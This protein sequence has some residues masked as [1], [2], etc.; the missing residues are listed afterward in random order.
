MDENNVDVMEEVITEEPLKKPTKKTTSKKSE[1]VVVKV[2][3]PRKYE[4][5]DV[6]EC[7]SVFPGRFYF[8]GPKTKAIYP[9][10]ANGDICYVEYQ[11]LLSAMLAKKKSI[12]APYIV[13]DD[14]ELING[15]H[16][17]A[18]KKVY[19]DMFPAR[20]IEKMIDMPFASFKKSFE[21]LPV[22]AKRSVMMAIST[23]VRDGSFSEM[24]KI[25]IVDEACGSNIAVLL[26]R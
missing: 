25:R 4:P 6:I 13:I 11:D 10:E 23:K 8:S 21:K 12:M 14:E 9:F 24:N 22:G 15:V 26:S 1:E 18:V 16:W 20:D 3:E 5:N 2:E 7:H 19:E 17:K